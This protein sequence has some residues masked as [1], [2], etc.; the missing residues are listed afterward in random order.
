MLFWHGENG[1]KITDWDLSRAICVQVSGP[2]DAGVFS[3]INR[4]AGFSFNP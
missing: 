2:R 4:T 1:V 3:S